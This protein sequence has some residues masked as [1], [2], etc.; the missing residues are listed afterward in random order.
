MKYKEFQNELGKAGL[1]AREFAELMCMNPNSVTNCSKKGKVPAHLAVIAA[2][3]GEMT[4]QKVDFRRVLARI[5]IQPKKPRG[6]ARPGKF[7]GDKRVDLPLPPTLPPAEPAGSR[8]RR[9]TKPDLP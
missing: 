2:L 1:A 4:E 3:M 5:D 8:K 6:A 9:T 7:G